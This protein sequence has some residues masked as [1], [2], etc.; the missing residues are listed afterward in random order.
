MGRGADSFSQLFLVI[1]VLAACCHAQNSAESLLSRI[2]EHQDRAE[3]LSDI[4]TR[5]SETELAEE[6][7]S[8]GEV[9]EAIMESV[10]PTVNPSDYDEGFLVICVLAACCHAQN[11]GE[12][13][14]SRIEEHQNNLRNWEEE[15]SRLLTT[16]LEK[17]KIYDHVKHNE[18]KLLEVVDYLVKKNMEILQNVVS[19][20]NTIHINMDKDVDG[21]ESL[22]EL[23]MKAL[24]N[25]L[26]EDEETVTHTDEN[27]E[28]N[29]DGAESLS[30]T[31]TRNLESELPE[32]DG[33]AGEVEEAKVENNEDGAETLSDIETRN[34]ERELAEGDGI[35]GEVEK[36]NVES[37]GPNV[38][39]DSD[40]DE[41]PK[42][43]EYPVYDDAINWYRYPPNRK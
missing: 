12:S 37:D 27:Q 1:C 22:S 7:G 19:E 25:E 26:A 28:S 32:E 41:N 29:E 2:E 42:S 3:T 33:I 20:L 10:Y 35:A 15:N 9:E 31:E 21:A 18:A 16:L 30:D 40:N 17:R 38:N 5:K 13:L 23:D 43:D 11:S 39:L 8:A 14:L 34:L 4:E 36:G 24:E 6:D